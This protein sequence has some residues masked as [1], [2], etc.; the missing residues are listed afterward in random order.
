MKAIFIAL[1]VATLTM[2]SLPATATID[3]YNTYDTLTALTPFTQKAS[4]AGLGGDPDPFWING[5]DA[6]KAFSDKTKTKPINVSNLDSCHGTQ[7]AYSAGKFHRLRTGFR[8][9][10]GH[11]R[12]FFIDH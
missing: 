2:F 9:E 10:P 8:T 11:Q 12:P 5:I 4:L 7:P 6:E 1:L 3:N